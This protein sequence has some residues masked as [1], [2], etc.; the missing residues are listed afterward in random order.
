MIFGMFHVD[1]FWQHCHLSTWSFFKKASLLKVFSEIPDDRHVTIDASKTYYIHQDVLDIIEDFK[2]SAETRN[3]RLDLIE[4][5]DHKD[6]ERH[7]HI[8][9]E[10]E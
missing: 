5:Y 9:T 1:C 8:H 7:M 6:A 2:I 10:K 3:I 4:L